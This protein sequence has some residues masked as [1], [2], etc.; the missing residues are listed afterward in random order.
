MEHICQPFYSTKGE[1]KGTGLDLSISHGIIQGQSEIR[2]ASQP[3][4]GAT[5]TVLLPIN[6]GQETALNSA[7]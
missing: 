2:I 7:Q 1:I 5:F 4:K 6:S 3:G